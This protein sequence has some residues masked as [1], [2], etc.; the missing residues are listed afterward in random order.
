M[1]FSILNV[2]VRS[3]VVN[4]RAKTLG[5]A[6]LVFVKEPSPFDIV[7]ICHPRCKRRSI[8][9]RLLEDGL[10]TLTRWDILAN[11]PAATGLVFVAEHET[12]QQFCAFGVWCLLQDGAG[13]W[14]GDEFAFGGEAELEAWGV[15]EGVR[16]GEGGCAAAV[17]GTNERARGCCAAYPAR[18]VGKQRVKPFLA[19]LL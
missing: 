10:R 3:Q 2:K 9:A 7:T 12:M 11:T 14:P 1:A 8:C 16:R 13:L 18:V 6:D 17:G 15:A 4:E 19:K 5:S